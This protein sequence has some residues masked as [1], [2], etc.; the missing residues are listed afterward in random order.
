MGSSVFSAQGSVVVWATAVVAF[1]AIIQVLALRDGS[2]HT[3]CT[4]GGL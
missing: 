1:P 3:C 2:S 4:L